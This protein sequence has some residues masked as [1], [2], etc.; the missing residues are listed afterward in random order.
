M[1]ETTIEKTTAKHSFSGL[2]TGVTA[3]GLESTSPFLCRAG[4]EIQA[5]IERVERE[6]REIW[7]RM[8]NATT[9]GRRRLTDDEI[10]QLMPGSARREDLDA[11]KAVGEKLK[12]LREEM[13][14]FDLS[15]TEHGN[16]MR[17]GVGLYSRPQMESCE[18]LPGSELSPPSIGIGS[19]ERARRYI[20]NEITLA[21]G[22]IQKIVARVKKTGQPVELTVNIRETDTETVSAWMELYKTND[23]GYRPFADKGHE[24]RDICFWAGSIGWAD[25]PRPR[26]VVRN[27]EWTPFGIALIRDVRYRFFS[28]NFTI[29]AE[30]GRLE[31]R[32]GVLR[33]PKGEP[34]SDGIP[35]QIIGIDPCIGSITDRPAFETTSPFLFREG[36]W[37]DRDI[38]RAESEQREIWTRMRNAT[39]R[40]RR[41]LT[42]E[43]IL[44]LMP[45]SARREH[46]EAHKLLGERLKALHEEL[47]L[48]NVSRTGRALAVREEAAAT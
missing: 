33:P 22:G 5:D 9:R 41:R 46:L 28:P 16:A 23:P 44:Q 25:S 32:D 43:E 12:A 6:Q 19:Q 1:I 35:A 21:P 14:L 4:R 40:G 3:A 10:L 2:K 34:G 29:G 42:D 11:H 20:A 45:W 24:M 31:L 36:Y 48:F 18:S 27:I 39:T 15:R 13:H 47:A 38:R 30:A 17:R 26:L 37:I 7:T 8:R